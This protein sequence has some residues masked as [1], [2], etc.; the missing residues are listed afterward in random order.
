MQE[1]EDIIEQT[2][3][4]FRNQQE[5]KDNKGSQVKYITKREAYEEESTLWHL[6]VLRTWNANELGFPFPLFKF[7]YIPSQG[8]HLKYKSKEG[9]KNVFRIHHQ[10]K[11]LLRIWRLFTSIEADSIWLSP[12]ANVK[13]EAWSRKKPLLK[14]IMKEIKEILN[15]E[16]GNN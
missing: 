3:L 8:Y 14:E 9:M 11:Y 7:S 6:N 15:A 4:R 10:L 1:E 5:L 12:L 13:L 16:W 2:N